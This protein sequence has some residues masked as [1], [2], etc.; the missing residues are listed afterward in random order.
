MKRI[1]FAC[2][3]KAEELNK[4]KKEIK[5]EE[6]FYNTKS[7]TISFLKKLTNE[8]I[9]EKLDNIV[10][11]NF[12]STK[13]IL[14]YVSSLPVNLRMLRLTSDLFPA[15]THYISDVYYKDS[16]IVKKIEKALLNL[17]NIARKHDIRLSFHPGQFCVLASEREDVVKNSIIEFEYHAY[18]ARSMGYTK[19][20]QDFKCNIHISGKN[21]INGFIDSYSKLSPEARNIITI[22]NTEYKYGIEECLLLANHCP[23]VF[24]IHHD[25]IYEESLRSANDDILKRVIDSWRGIRPVMHY[26]Q[27]KEQVLIDYNSKSKLNI[28]S[29]LKEKINKKSLS[30]HSSMLWNDNFNDNLSF[31]IKDFDIM[32]EAKNKNLASIDYFYKYK[33]FFS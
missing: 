17:G 1:G 27:S 28:K 19:Q 31:F 2:K 4:T 15:Y 11:C 13:N 33:N 6:A 9:F 29:L 22:E 32:I 12:E 18:I 26:S 24:D 5:E 21:G 8:K 16:T 20:F 3:Y 14:N 7:T 10:D 30:A 25:W 23:I